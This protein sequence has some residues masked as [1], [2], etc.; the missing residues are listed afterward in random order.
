MNAN[1]VEINSDGFK[2]IREVIDKSEKFVFLTSFLFYDE[3]V[4]DLLIDGIKRGLTV[5]LLTTPAVAARSDE[6]KRAAKKLQEK[7]RSSGVSIIASDW[8]VGQPQRTT[9]TFAG[10]RSPTWFAM[11][12]KFIVTD[13]QAVIMSADLTQDFNEGGSW[14]SFVVYNAPEKVASFL[15]KYKQL[16]EFFLKVDE[17]ISKEY[18]DPKVLPRKLLRGY[19]VREEEASVEDGVY[20]L[21]LDRYGRQTLEQ[22]IDKAEEF[23]YFVYETF[24]DDKLSFHV[25]KKLVTNPKIDLR[26]LSPPL[27]VYQQN[28]IKARAN[29]VQLASYGAKIKNIQKLRAKM[30]ITDKGVISGS[31]DISV[32]GLG[33]YRT[34][35]KLKLWVESTEIMDI[36]TSS[37]IISLAKEAY[38]KIFERASYQYGKWYKRDAEKSL[39]SAGAAIIANEAKET[40]GLLIFNEGRRSIERIRKISLI[41]V[42]IAKL[43]NKT[44]PYVKADNVINAERILLLKENNEL[45]LKSLIKLLGT[46]D[47]ENFLKRIGS[48]F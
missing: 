47:G 24:Y 48:A 31:F 7:L 11:H 22:I 14:D 43:S 34:E 5:E 42:E 28:P 6:L 15:K 8:E 4:A 25:I 32:M 18:I 16:K 10:G 39:R 9:S 13:K 2:V 38:L 41:A 3:K 21:P 46:M 30:I 40:L 29:F 45:D 44:K 33:K 26:V 1:K 19:P 20:I 27:S 17:K 23:I 35:H 37:E 36:N 12:C